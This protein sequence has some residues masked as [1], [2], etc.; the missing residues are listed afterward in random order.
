MKLSYAKLVK[1]TEQGVEHNDEDPK[2]KAGDRVRIKKYDFFWSGEDFVAKEIKNTVLWTY[3]IN[4][5][6]G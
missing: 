4:D 5:I 2:L 3:Y 6:I 1:Y